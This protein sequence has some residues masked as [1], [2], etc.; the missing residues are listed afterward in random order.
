[1]ERGKA[2][3]ALVK[4]KRKNM[5]VTEAIPIMRLTTILIVFLCVH[6]FA[7]G[8]VERLFVKDYDERYTWRNAERERVDSFYFGL[9]PLRTANHKLHCRI[10]YTNQIIDIYQAE[11]STYHGKLI[12]EITGEDSQKNKDPDETQQINKHYIFDKIELDPMKAGIV[13]R[14]LIASGQHDIPIDTLVKTWKHNFLHCDGYRYEF[15]VEG[16]YSLQTFHCPLGQDDSAAYKQLIIANHQFVKEELQ[17]DSLYEI[18]LGNLPRGRTYSRNGYIMIYLPT[19]KQTK[20]WQQ[21]QPQRDFMRSVKDTIDSYLNTLLADQTLTDHKIACF[22][23][24]RLTFGKSGRLKK[25]TLSVYDKPTLENSIDFAD[26]LRN[27][28]EIRRCKSAIRK[29]FR[30]S[31]FSFLK[32]QS[33]VYRTLSFE[34]E[35]KFELR[36]DTIY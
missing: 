29:I 34:A 22:E 1:V 15:F 2:N 3:K 26:Y 7:I 18:F 33:E 27:R 9:Q 21:R 25:I 10:R 12:N 36:D 5:S 4:D 16:K 14:T 28:K 31:D 13:L 30:K 6:T 35:R 17:L 32:M 19:A 11:D 24:Y 23:N 8:Q 20:L